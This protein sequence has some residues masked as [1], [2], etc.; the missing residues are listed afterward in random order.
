MTAPSLPDPP[1][2]PL[3]ARPLGPGAAAWYAVSDARFLLVAIRTLVLQVAHP[4]VGAGVE[5]HSVYKSSPYARLWRTT[6][7]LLRQ[8]FGGHRAAEEGRRL[9]QMH[10]EIKGVDGQGRRYHALDPGAYLWVHATMFDAWRLFLRD[11]GPGLSDAQELQLYDEWR[12]VGL[13]IGCKD[14]LLPRSVEEFDRYFAG[15]VETL[16]DNRVVQDLLH[17]PPKAPPLVPQLVMDAV[18]RPLLSLQRS[19]VAETLPGDLAARFGLSRSERTAR[20]ARRLGRLAHL[21]RFV[22]G[23]LRRSPLARYAMWQTSRDPRTV[24]EPVSYP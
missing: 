24:P 13:L 5:Q 17:N 1:R 6:V 8:V 20:Q 15:I 11:Y 16:E 4:M 9:I 12:R 7:S 21:L 10:A 2:P 19:F 22:P 3:A 23:L 14:R 18:S